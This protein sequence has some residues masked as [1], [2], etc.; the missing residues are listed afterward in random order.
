MPD[1]YLSRPG[2]ISPNIAFP[3]PNDRPAVSTDI[4]VLTLT[5]E[6]ELA[7]VLIDLDGQRQLPGT[8]MMPG[9]TLK[10][11]A[12]RALSEC[13]TLEVGEMHLLDVLDEPARDPR[14]WM[15]SISFFAAVPYSAVELLL[16]E[17]HGPNPPYPLALVPV[18]DLHVT[19]FTANQ[20][21]VIEQAVDKITHEYALRPDP[22]YFIPAEEVTLFDLRNVHEIVRGKKILKDNFRRRMTPHLLDTGHVT[23]GRLGKPARLYRRRQVRVP[24]PPAQETSL[25]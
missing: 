25:G 19:S 23:Q 3:D 7:V 21:Q 2:N 1:A 8:F 4:A 20:S 13:L 9:E 22:Y 17:E 15:L 10:K 16:A 5:P 14:G 11:S 6:R 12:R 18:S 24:R